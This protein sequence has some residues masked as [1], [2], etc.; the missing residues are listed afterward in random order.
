M[1]DHFK[2][3]IEIEFANADLREVERTMLNAG[4]NVHREGYNHTARF[5]PLNHLT[6]LEPL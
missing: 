6:K 3:G 4:I 5:H 2:F 1:I